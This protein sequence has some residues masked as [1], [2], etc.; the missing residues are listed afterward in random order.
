MRTKNLLVVAASVMCAAV[1]MSSCGAKDNKTTKEDKATEQVDTT[2]VEPKDVFK[3]HEEHK[4]TSVFCRGQREKIRGAFDVCPDKVLDYVA[5][6]SNCNN[7]SI[8]FIGEP[9]NT[10]AVTNMDVTDAGNIFFYFLRP[11]KDD[12]VQDMVAISPYLKIVCYWASKFKWDIQ[13]CDEFER[14]KSMN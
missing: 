10:Y 12:T 3:G 5:I 1:A 13:R 4:L 8:K 6:C 2:R 11:E 14:I 9:V 7:I